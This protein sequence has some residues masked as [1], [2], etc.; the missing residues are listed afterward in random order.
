M[1]P[2]RRRVSFA[3][4]V[5]AAAGALALPLTSLLQAQALV[6]WAERCFTDD[7]GVE[8]CVLKPIACPTQR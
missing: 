6:C 1:R 7:K 5:A 4:T 8:R 2:H 3:V